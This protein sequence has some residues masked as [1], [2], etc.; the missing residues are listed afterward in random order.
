[1]TIIQKAGDMMYVLQIQYLRM[2]S[3]TPIHTSVIPPGHE[4]AWYNIRTCTSDEGNFYLPSLFD[5]H[6]TATRLVP[7]TLEIL[8]EW[9]QKGNWTRSSDE[10]TAYFMLVKTILDM[11]SSNGTVILVQRL[12]RTLILELSTERNL[13]KSLM[14]RMIALL[15]TPVFSYLPRVRR[16]LD[17]HSIESCTRI[18]SSTAPFAILA[19]HRLVQRC[20]TGNIPDPETDSI[21]LKDADDDIVT[22]YE[23]AQ[24]SAVDDLPPI[25]APDPPEPAASCIDDGQKPISTPERRT[26]ENVTQISPGTQAALET[27][28]ACN[29][30]PE[31][32]ELS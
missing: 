2:L 7:G 13:S 21:S 9:S 27:L 17:R 20:E 22:D 28:A 30:E 11:T 8:C 25:P 23:D 16:R 4:Y 24:L 3:D 26:K 32:L 14:R 31:D 6:R 18:L 10:L 1:M 12:S 15:C 29:I 19:L 5:S